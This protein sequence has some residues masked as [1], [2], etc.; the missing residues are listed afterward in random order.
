MGTNWTCVMAEGKP[1]LS[2]HSNSGEGG[3]RQGS[4]LSGW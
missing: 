2:M 4:T 3:E 1:D